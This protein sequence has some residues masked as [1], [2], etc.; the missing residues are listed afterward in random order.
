MKLFESV[1]IRGMV[2]RNRILMAPMLSNLG[3]K[4]KRGKAYF[5]A[6][7]RG[8]VGAIVAYGI[9][10]DFFIKDEAWGNKEGRKLFLEGTRMLTDE[11]HNLETKIGVQ[12]WHAN[13][14]PAVVKG[15]FDGG[16]WVAPSA[17]IE[18]SPPHA[19]VPT[20]AHLREMT[21]EEIESLIKTFGKAAAQ[22]KEVGFDFVEIHGAHS[23][24]AN[25]FFSPADN[26]R[27]DQ[28]GGNLAG[29]M[30]FGIE[31]V[32]AMRKALGE[33]FPI[34]FRFPAEETKPGGITLP[35]SIEYAVELEKAG[36]DVLNV[37]IGTSNDKRGM[38][39]YIT[40]PYDRPTGTYVHLAEAIKH[41]VGI[42]V[43]AVGRINNPGLAETIL[44]ENK[45]DLVTMGRQLIADPE[46]PNKVMN[47]GVDDIRPCISCCECTELV[48]TGRQL[49]CAVNPVA[50]REVEYDM[51]PSKK[52]KIIIIGGG[53][54][55]METAAISASKGHKVVLLE[56]GD[57]LGGQLLLSGATPYKDTHAHLTKY[58]IRQVE[59]SGVEVRLGCDVD[60]NYIQKENPDVVIV[61]A[62]AVPVIPAIPGIKQKNVVT[63]LDVISGRSE[64]GEKVIVVG[65]GMVGLETAEFL[66][67]MGKEVTLF[68]MLEEVGQDT[69][70]VL[71]EAI[72]ERLNQADVKIKTN[73]E[74]VEITSK[75]VKLKDGDKITSFEGSSVVLACGMR[76]SNDLKG[77]LEKVIKEIYTI[78]DCVKPRRIRQAIE[79]GLQAGYET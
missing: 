14:F 26:H 11:I 37:S 25:Q 3:Y 57:R 16:E 55:G 15:N 7:A 41:R 9:P 66:S 6:R 36:V 39:Y 44:C 17:R 5:S 49:R 59:R 38:G 29:R 31:C 40:P 79:E 2:L 76:S 27:T 72:K 75:G 4:S 70:P 12:L 34:F 18:G 78:G 74:V 71:K 42:F 43:A 69:I 19:M 20:S 30:G 24:L 46:W 58:L 60:I 13:R 73:I 62:G 56:K 10:P 33:N 52:K 61:A 35:D 50:G 47:G 68:E 77:Q 54:A 22:A 64:V 51:Q 8:G 48:M 21:I 53:P 28:Y 67:T 63:A 45:S 32:K 1:M 23:Y 65:G